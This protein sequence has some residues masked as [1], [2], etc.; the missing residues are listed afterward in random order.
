MS[1]ARALPIALALVA[2]LAGC[3]DVD[4]GQRPDGG[5]P[6]VDFTLG[7]LTFHVSSGV[8]VTGAGTLTFYLS[9]QPDTCSAIRFTPVGR[10]TALAVKIAPPADG[11]TTAT[12]T[13]KSIPAPGEA[14]GTLAITLHGTRIGGLTPTGGS[15][16][17]SPLG[18]GSGRV[19]ITALDVG[20]AETSDRLVTGGLTVPACSP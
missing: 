6:K 18:D 19:T 17:W 10:L 20:F 16:A 5:S 14:A 4:S 7:T 12:L 3:G 9:D 8:A 11:S 15:V 1:P 2:A 13:A